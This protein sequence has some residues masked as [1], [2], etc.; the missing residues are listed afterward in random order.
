MK[1]DDELTE[2]IKSLAQSLGADLFGIAD[3][4]SELLQRAPEGHRPQDYI[5][6]PRSVLVLGMV[7][8]YPVLQTAPSTIY[9]KHYDTINECLNEVAYKVTKSLQEEGYNS[10]CFPETD[11]YKV[12]W[13]QYNAGSQNFV[14]S[15]NHMAVAE[16]AGLGKKGL[17]GVVL[18][19]KYG[20]RQ[21]WVS[22]ITEGALRRGEPLEGEICLEK[23][24]P[25]SC[26]RC[27]NSC[28]IGAITVERGTDVR[29]CWVYWNKL[30]DSGAACGLCIKSCPIGLEMA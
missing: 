14:P 7:V 28:P 4:Y 2:R 27:I 10:I 6:N 8:I 3:P 12:F 19:P 9:S 11:N 13:A 23:R 22:I 21:R 24:E 29:A 30:R 5:K 18:T 16:A 1:K 26:K 25:G 20:P 15:F 17:C